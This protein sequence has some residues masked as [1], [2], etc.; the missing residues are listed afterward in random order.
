ME[1]VYINKRMK[2][3]AVPDVSLTIIKALRTRIFT[4]EY[5]ELIDFESG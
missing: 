5:G 4:K 1:Q 3:F 2:M